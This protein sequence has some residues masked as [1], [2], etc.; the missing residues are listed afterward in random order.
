MEK[1]DF[2]KKYKELYSP[3]SK[4][5]VVVEVPTFNFLMIDG[6][7]NP[8]TSKEYQEAISTLYTVSYTLKFMIK[9][10]KQ[11]IDYTVMPLEGLWWA[12]EMS[13]FLASDKDKW[14]WTAMIMQ[15]PDIITESLVKEALDK[16]KTKNPPSISKIRFGTLAEGKAAQ[17]M[18]FG[19]YAEEGPTIKRLHD[20]ITQNGFELAGKHHEVYLSD[21]RRSAP[22]TLKTVIRQ[23]VKPK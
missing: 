19:S 3:S 2:L 1:L 11:A 16:A 13:S 6:S 4:E 18:H 22:E 5:V 8:N 15:P 17:I 9:K 20:F 14:K 23:A 10:S 12:D 21:P 7:G